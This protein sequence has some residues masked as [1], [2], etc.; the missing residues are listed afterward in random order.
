MSTTHKFSECVFYER[1]KCDFFHNKKGNIHQE[2]VSLSALNGD[3]HQHGLYI[4]VDLS[5]FTERSLVM[6]R[7]GVSDICDDNNKICPYHRYSYG[8]FWRPSTLCQSPYHDGKKPKGTHSLPIEY[9]KKLTEM[10]NFKGNINYRFPVGQKVCRRCSTRIKSDCESKKIP[11]LTDEDPCSTIRVS[12]AQAQERLE[13]LKE[14]G[15]TQSESESHFGDFSS[16]AIYTEEISL[17]D[18]NQLL[19][20]ISKNIKPLTYQIHQPVDH[21]VISTIRKVKHHYESIMQEFS[22]FICE[23]M[24]P[25]Q[26]EDLSKLFKNNVNDDIEEQNKLDP[27]IQCI[28]EAYNSAPTNKWKLFLLSTVSNQFSREKLQKIFNCTRYKIDESRYIRH[29]NEQFNLMNQN[30]IRRERLEK[31]QLEFFFDFLFSSGLIQDVAHGT[32]FVRFDRGDEI[33]IPYVVRTM[34]KSHIFQLYQRH[35]VQ[36]SYDQPLSRSTVLRVLDA[37]KMREKKTMCGLDSFSVDGNTGFDTLQRL[38]KELRIE[39][40]EEKNLLQLIKLSRNYLKFEYGQNVSKDD[41]NCATHCRIFALSHP[42]EKKLKR[43]CKHSKH[44]MS[45]IKCN[46]LLALFCRIEELMATIPSSQSKDELE[47]DLSTAKTDILSWMFH[48][49]R[50]VQ[51]DESK[52]FVMS[53]LDSKSGL[54]LSDWAM[55][56][57]PQSHREKMDEWFG[58]K[59]ISL[60]VDVLYFRDTNHILRKMTYFTA[61]DRCLQDMSSVLCVF[62][63]VIDQIK[64]D[65]PNLTNLYTRSDNAGCYAGASVIIARKI[66]CDGADICLKRTDF[67]EPQRGKDQADRDIAVA[68]SCLKAYTNRGGNLINATSI[69]EALDESFGKLCGSKTSV[70]ALNEAKCVLPKIKIEGITKYHSV[71]FN[72]KSVTFWQYFDIGTG[73]SKSINNCNCA[74]RTSLILPFSNEQN[75]NKEFVMKSTLT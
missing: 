21:L 37:C 39:D 52:Q 62:A 61:I 16:K 64:R 22:S 10:E 43:S 73:I 9:Y 51:Q 3:V 18:V 55:K 46:S 27:S 71:A 42:L 75:T 12:K 60:H 20:A 5:S 48:I 45:C 13:E 17:N 33:L 59:G 70:I 7:M 68:K 2:L 66:I 24:A 53:Q 50:G 15:D 28:V 74:L 38:V 23:A 31:H 44:S 19:E 54:L 29:Q 35:C 11:T 6:N 41:T 57:L 30:V 65:L 56:V 25:G 40:A 67:S 34:M 26:G 72:D 14:F 49:I 1:G 4:G 8:L 69:K 36:T 58:K 32:T 47:V 63:Y